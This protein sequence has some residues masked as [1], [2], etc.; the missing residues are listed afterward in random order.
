MNTTALS[1]FLIV[2]FNH[3][4]SL[5]S[6]EILNNRIILVDVLKD[7]TTTNSSIREVLLNVEFGERHKLNRADS[8]CV[9]GGH[10]GRTVME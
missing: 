7:T 10:G 1:E 4:S 6:M 3:A 8:P 2:S 5:S 9:E